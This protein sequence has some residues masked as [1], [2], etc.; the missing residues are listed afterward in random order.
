[1]KI[2]TLN[3]KPAAAMWLVIVAVFFFCT[4]A[5]K[6]DNKFK[7]THFQEVKSEVG[8]DGRAAVGSPEIYQVRISPSL[9]WDLSKNGT[10]FFRTAGWI[11]IL[12]L[13][14]FMALSV[15]GTLELG[16]QGFN[17]IVFISLVAAAACIFGAYSSA[18]SNNYVDLSKEAYE[19][20][21]DSPEELAALFDKPL[22]K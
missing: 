6:K 13:G 20:I 19:A 11:I 21:K 4:N 2:K 7:V 17:L 15:T 5:V 9:T 12:L 8:S 22:I 1:M 18:F 10:G 14:V 16:K 3:W